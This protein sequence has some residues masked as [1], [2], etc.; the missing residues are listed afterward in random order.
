[1]SPRS[2]L[3]G[4]G[5]YLPERVVSNDEQARDLTTHVEQQFQAVLDADRMPRPRR[6]AR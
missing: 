3:A 5:G 4:C 1:M 6:P 2:I